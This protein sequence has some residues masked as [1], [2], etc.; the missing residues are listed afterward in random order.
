M[1]LTM[2]YD[3]DIDFVEYIKKTA[4]LSLAL[5]VF[6]MTIAFIAVSLIVLA[7]NICLGTNYDVTPIVDIWVNILSFTYSIFQ[8]YFI[9]FYKKKAKK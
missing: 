3:P 5:A 2:F 1:N 8:F 9:L 7:M 4:V 6:F